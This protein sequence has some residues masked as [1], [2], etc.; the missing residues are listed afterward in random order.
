MKEYNHMLLFVYKY[1]VTIPGSNSYLVVP[2]CPA[3]PAPL[4]QQL[5]SSLPAK[6]DLSLSR[7]WESV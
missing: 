5:F 6:P 4:L 7:R 2:L 1:H 3:P